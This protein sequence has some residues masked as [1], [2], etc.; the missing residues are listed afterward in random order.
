MTITKTPIRTVFAG[1]DPVGLAEFQIGEV[2]PIDH[3]GTAANTISGARINFS[4]DDSNIRSLFS[5]TGAGSYDNSTGIINVTGG[6]TTVAGVEGAV[7]NAAL[8][9]GIEETGFLTTANI[10]EVT[11]L[12]FTEARARE[13]V[14]ATG[15]IQYDNST[16]VF[17]FTQ[18]NSDTV[19]EGVTNLYFSNTRAR[20]AF[21]A[22]SGI[23]I[24]EGVI[25]VASTVDYGLIDGAVTASN[26]YG[27]I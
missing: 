16:G 7:S 21:T 6:V 17:S 1:N 15:S 9:A 25:S 2:I 12:Y 19:V 24:E 27:S 26:D 4:V 22:G 10:T 18:G 13:S 20:D 11:N 14:S 3:G 23:Q 5:V 8:L